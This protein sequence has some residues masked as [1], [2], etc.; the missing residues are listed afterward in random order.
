M[1]QTVAILRDFSQPILGVL[2]EETATHYKLRN[3][4]LLAPRSV[5][6]EGQ[7]NIDQIPVEFL[8]LEPQIIP[9]RAILQDQN[10]DIVMSFKKEDNLI[11]DIKLRDNIIQ[12]YLS[13]PFNKAKTPEVIK[14]F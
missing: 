3:P 5:N 13:M 10:A 9:L 8:V 11:N 12:Q 2:E 7:F 6:N 14:L 1:Q 4:V